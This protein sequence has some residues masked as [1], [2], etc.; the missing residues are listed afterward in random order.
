MPQGLFWPVM[1]VEK[2][3]QMLGVP[4]VLVDDDYSQL[5][6][7]IKNGVEVKKKT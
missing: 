3:E 7:L 1:M 4:L 2:P 6:V 5:V